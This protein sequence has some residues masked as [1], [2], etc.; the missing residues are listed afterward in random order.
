MLISSRRANKRLW[1]IESNVFIKSANTAHVFRSFFFLIFNKERRENEPSRQSIL[2]KTPNC[3][4]VLTKD[5]R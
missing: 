2:G 1:L 4:G 5:E 3:K